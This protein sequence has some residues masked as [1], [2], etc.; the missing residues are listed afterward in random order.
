MLTLVVV[1]EVVVVNCVRFRE[2]GSVTKWGFFH[3]PT[4]RGDLDR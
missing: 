1:S 4:G 3:Q 2:V